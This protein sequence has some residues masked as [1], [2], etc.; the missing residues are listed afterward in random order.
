MTRFVVAAALAAAVLAACSSSNSQN[1]TE[2][3]NPV[4]VCADKGVGPTHPDYEKCLED[5][6]RGR[7]SQVGAA[8]STEYGDCMKNQSDATFA[9]DQVRR[10][11]F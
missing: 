11:G 10:W 4:D 8:E 2:A 9:R 3:E 6:A 7:C 5:T 1:T